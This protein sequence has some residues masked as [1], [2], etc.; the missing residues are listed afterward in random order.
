MSDT[1]ICY[2]LMNKNTG[3]YYGIFGDVC[4]TDEALAF[5]SKDSPVADIILHRTSNYEWV[6][7][8]LK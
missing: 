8:I 1:T 5:P 6:E 3:W 2:Y 4:S 7:E